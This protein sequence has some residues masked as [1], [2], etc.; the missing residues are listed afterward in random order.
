MLFQR[1]GNVHHQAHPWL[2]TQTLSYGKIVLRGS[3]EAWKR[4]NAIPSLMETLMHG[5]LEAWEQGNFGAQ[6]DA[7]VEGA[8]QG[9][10]TKQ[11]L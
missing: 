5:S 7:D 10:P 4:G 11:A 3:V 6:K 8:V 9:Q 2:A 1:S